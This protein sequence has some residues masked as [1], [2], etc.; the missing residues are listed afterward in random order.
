MNQLLDAIRQER[1]ELLLSQTKITERLIALDQKEQ[2][3]L[4][5]KVRTEK[6]VPL[7]FGKNVIQWQGGALAISGKGYKFIRALY[8]ADEMHLDIPALEEIVW[9]EEIGEGTKAVIKQNTFRVTLLR[10]SETLEKA[11]FPYRLSPIRSEEKTEVV[12]RA[13][14]KKPITKR[15]QSEIIGAR[16]GV[17]TRRKNVTAD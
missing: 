6:P 13:V 8:E 11:K 5:G 9:N 2:E 1:R 7:I 12:E 15:I 10:L 16:L 3:I 17:T 4:T 14:G